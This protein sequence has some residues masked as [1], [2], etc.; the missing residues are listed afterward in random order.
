MVVIILPCSIDCARSNYPSKGVCHSCLWVLHSSPLP[1]SH[2]YIYCYSVFMASQTCFSPL[3]LSSPMDA[4]PDK[5]AVMAIVSVGFVVPAHWVCDSWAV[6]CLGELILTCH[7]KRW[8]KHFTKAEVEKQKAEILGSLL[9]LFCTNKSQGFAGPLPCHGEKGQYLLR[10][11]WGAQACSNSPL[12]AQG[13]EDG[14]GILCFLESWLEK[15]SL[16]L[17]K[18]KNEVW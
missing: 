5:L 9:S 4:S 12:Q 10:A 7:H 15:N 3:S 1:T 8:D 2:A 14:H 13:Q 11:R 17:K 16:H 18:K 6:W